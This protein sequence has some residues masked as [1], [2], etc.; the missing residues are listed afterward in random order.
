MSP[1]WYSAPG[2]RGYPSVTPRPTLTSRFGHRIF[3][4]LH[5]L[6]A[7][8][9]GPAHH[10]HGLAVQPGIQLVIGQR[11]RPLADGQ[12]PRVLLL[13]IGLGLEQRP[14]QLLQARQGRI[15]EGLPSRRYRLTHQRNDFGRT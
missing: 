7:D 13:G 1:C 8:A 9:A 11:Q 3:H 15:V 10:D 6:G 5:Q 14:G 4:L 2:S 12:E